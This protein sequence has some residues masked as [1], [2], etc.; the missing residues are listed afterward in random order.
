MNYRPV[1]I[2]GCD[3]S[4]TTL[5]GDLL[6]SSH[7]TITTPESQ[8]VHELLLHLQ[9]SSFETPRAATHWLLNHFRYAAWDLRLNADELENLLQLDNPRATIEAIVHQYVKQTHPEKVNADVWIDHTPDNFK[10]YSQLKSIFP[11]ARF[12][13]IVR[14]GRAVCASIRPLEWGP[15]NAYTAS[16]H[17]AERLQQALIVESA[18]AD[19]CYRVR[20]EDLI[21]HPEKTLRQLCEFI[22]FPFDKAMING[23]GLA[24]PE[25]TRTQHNLVGQAPKAEKS[26]QWRKKMSQQDLRDFES[27]P[28]SHLLL[29]KMG[30]QNEFSHPPKLTTLH[31]LNCYCHEFIFYLINRLRHRRMEQSVVTH[32]GMGME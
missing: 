16:R 3:R 5:L 19:N 27:Y 24:V 11:E 14:D 20:Y 13:H 6:G 28:L 1:F 31:T 12:I 22:E 32:L 2:A 21:T 17:W 29:E 8:F 23:G 9:L 15:N 4:G 10:Y 7:W 26:N 25:F 18:E 30:Y